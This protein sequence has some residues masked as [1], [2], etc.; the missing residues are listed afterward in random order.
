MDYPEHYESDVLSFFDDRPDA[1]AL[2]RVLA[3]GLARI[4]PEG[5]VKV[6]KSQI[7]FYDG[8]L[9]AMASLPKRKRDP[10]LVVTFGLGRREPSPRVGV[11]VEPCPG[12]WTHHVSVTRDEELDGELLGWLR[13]AWDFN[14]SK[15]R[16]GSP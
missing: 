6:Q 7:S 9:F 5:R 4:A 15:G 16:R 10:G 14:Q 2:Y 3:A 8:G 11:A 12:R 1:L 13:E